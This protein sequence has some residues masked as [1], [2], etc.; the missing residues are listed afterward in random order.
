M[1]IEQKR[2][3]RVLWFIIGMFL[4]LILYL[5]YFQIFKREKIIDNEYNKRLWVDENAIIKGDILDSQGNILTTTKKDASE[6]N[7][8]E[9]TS[10]PAFSHITGYSSKKYGKTGI[11]KY[12]YNQLMSVEEKTTFSQLKDIIITKE[13]GNDVKLTLN[14]KLQEFSYE[15]LKGHKGSIVLLNADTGEVYVMTSR[16]SFNPNKIVESWDDLINDNNS[17]L[18]NRST[19]GLYTPGSVF[20][21]VTASALEENKEFMDL[22]YE[23]K[24]NTIIDGYKISNHEGKA[25][26]KIGLEKALVHSVNTYFAELG[27]KLGREKMDDMSKRFLFSK[28]IPFDIPV[29]ESVSPFI[30]GQTKTELAAACFGQGKTLVTPLNMALISAGLGNNGVIMKSILVKEITSTDKSVIKSYKP[31]ILAEPLPARIAN[32]IENYMYSVVNNG[33]RAKVSGVKV[34]GKTGTAETTSGKTHAWFTG[35]AKK[36]NLNIAIAVVLEEDGT[37]GGR[38]AAPIAGEIFKET[39]KVLNE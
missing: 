24:G 32:K 27:V 21:L 15:K 30:A 2:M 3:I 36:N 31:E 10:G 26:G 12:F 6:N 11:E 13:R 9:Y 16:P 18:L 37:L 22:S 33:S 8:R 29:I 4:S 14:K 7:Y 28:K 19:Q 35:F 38:T 20:K 34:G 39:V 25:Y 1:N 23:D 17:P 5:S